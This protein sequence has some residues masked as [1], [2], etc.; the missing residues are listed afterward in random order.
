M[1]NV[2]GQTKYAGSVGYDFVG[3]CFVAF[4]A[5]QFIS[6][7]YIRD[8]VYLWV[9]VPHVIQKHWSPA[10]IDETMVLKIKEKRKVSKRENKIICLIFH[11]HLLSRLSYITITYRIIPMLFTSTWFVISHIVSCI[12]TSY[13][14]IVSHITNC[15][16]H[17]KV[18]LPS[19]FGSI[20]CG[21][22]PWGQSPV[23]LLHTSSP[24]HWPHGALQL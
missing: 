13:I 23:T 10:K 6:L 24:L 2:C 11:L 12:T 22:H 16:V 18:F 15:I 4:S 20:Q 3:N 1:A 17:C 14:F 9:N 7:L 8:D 19:H 21:L 5:S